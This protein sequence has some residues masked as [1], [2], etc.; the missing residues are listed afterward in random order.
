MTK[1]LQWRILITLG[2]VIF[3][4]L[5]MLP[6]K[7]KINLGLDLQGGMHLV[8]KVDTEKVPEEAREDA[9]NRALEVIRNRIDQF[10]VREPLIQ[11]QGKNAIVVQ[12]PGITDRARALELIGKTALL[13]FKIVESDEELNK[14]AG[15]GD[16]PDGYRCR[17]KAPI[18]ST[19]PRL[20]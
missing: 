12:L 6:L 2:V 19:F 11:R 7:E 16:I 4:L 1:K 10:G 9:P 15:E 14:R 18:R 13:E 5:G 3:A 17:Y 8:L 20:R